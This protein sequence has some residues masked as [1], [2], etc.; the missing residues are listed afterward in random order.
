MRLTEQQENNNKKEKKNICV[1]WGSNPPTKMLTI[2]KS[3][4]ITTM[5][6]RM[7]LFT[8]N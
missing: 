7:L 5:L 6:E 8:A 2:A 4:V 3:S 1:S